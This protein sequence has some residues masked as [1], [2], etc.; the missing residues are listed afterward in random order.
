MVSVVSLLLTRGADVDIHG[1][2]AIPHSPWM[3]TPLWYA[4]KY[5]NQDAIRAILALGPDLTIRDSGGRMPLR[6]A[7]WCGH[8]EIAR[9]L[10]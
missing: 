8:E 2:S 6:F 9:M 10:E 1:K 7:T 4:I 3:D 5:N